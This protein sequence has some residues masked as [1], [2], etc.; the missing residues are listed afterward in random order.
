MT[1]VKD[2]RLL[3]TPSTSATVKVKV[4][5]LT[6][7]TRY[8]TVPCTMTPALDSHSLVMGIES[9]FPHKPLVGRRTSAY[10]KTPGR[11]SKTNGIVIEA[12]M[13]AGRRQKLFRQET[14][15][16]EPNYAGVSVI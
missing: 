5:Q 1:G 7:A 6:A 15:W 12:K 11:S 10:W 14:G 4:Q 9:R 13:R 16:R 3:A 2:G 8:L